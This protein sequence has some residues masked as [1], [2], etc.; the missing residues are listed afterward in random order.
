MWFSGKQSAC[1]CRTHLFDP[2][3]RRSPGEENGNPLEFS[4]LE[5]SWTEEPSRLQ[6]MG[7]QKESE[8]T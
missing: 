6:S 4:C 2:E 3:S 1:Q 8:M 7:L 5:M